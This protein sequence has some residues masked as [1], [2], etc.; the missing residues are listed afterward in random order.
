MGYTNL[1]LGGTMKISVLMSVYKNDNP[2][3]FK[4][5]L[6]S[7]ILQQERKPEQVVVV[8]D[9]PVSEKFDDIIN[10]IQEDNKNIEITTIKK[11]KNQGL[12]AALNTGLQSCKYEWVARMDSDDIS[13]SDRLRKQEE[14]LLKHS[15]IDVLGGFIAEFNENPNDIISVRKVGMNQTDIIRMCKSRTPMNHVSV[16]YRKEAIKEVGGYAEDFGKLEDYRLW[17]DLL[18]ANKKMANLDD[19]IVKVRVGNGFIERR[20][21]KREIEDWDMLQRYL[22]KAGLVNRW[23]SIRNKMYIRTFIYMPGWLKKFL[24]KTILRGN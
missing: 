13:T 14:Y 20:S 19:V 22:L 4:Q 15:E 18:S 11:E 5:A 9:G 12:A 17:V 3:F 2:D 10:Q 6:T 23:E 1:L 24:Y 7:V 21:D 8:Y 16:I